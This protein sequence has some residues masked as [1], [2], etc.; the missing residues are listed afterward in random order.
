MIL[1]IGTDLA[2]IDRIAAHARAVRRPVPQPRLHAD[3]TAQGRTPRRHA[4]HL[5]QALGRER[6][7][8]QGAGHRAA[9]GHRVE[10]HGGKNLPTGQPV[11][12]VTGWAR[13]R[14]EQMTPEGHEAIIHVSL[15]DDHPWAQAFVV[16]EARPRTRRRNFPIV[17][18]GV[19]AKRCCKPGASLMQILGPLTCAPRADHATPQDRRKGNHQEGARMA[20]ESQE[21]RIWETVKTVVYALLIAGSSAPCSSSPSGSR[22]AR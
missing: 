20:S 1:G 4:R 8:F 13:E 2:N 6:G 11:M 5:R 14:L 7:L 18:P 12:E 21:G 10:G 22:R 16:I 3:R 15:T 19:T 17:R 9:H